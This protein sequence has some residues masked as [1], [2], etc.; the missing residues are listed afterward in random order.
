[1]LIGVSAVNRLDSKEWY[2]RDWFAKEEGLIG[3]MLVT[4]PYSYQ[5]HIEGM[6]RLLLVVREQVCLDQETEHWLRDQVRIQVRRVKPAT[7]ERWVA[8]GERSVV[9]WLVQGEVLSD[10]TGYLQELRCR[11]QEW[12][13]LLR[14]QKLLCEFSGFIRTYM[15]A[16]QDL[17]NGQ[18]LDSYSNVLASLQYWA[19]IA[20]IEEGLHPELTVWGQLRK[21]NPGIYKLYEELTT[22]TDTLEKRAQ[23]VLLACEFSVLTKMRSSCALLIR[24]LASRDKPWTVA[25]LQQE[26]HLLG[27]PLDLSLLLQK[28]AKR[29]CI[30]ELAT[31]VR[32]HGTM[33]RELRYAAADD[34]S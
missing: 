15:L 10:P 22:S 30:R 25:E 2:Y 33:K 7:L 28:L 16:K 5:P 17:K 27:L 18:V 23:L 13:P 19:H 20:L 3:L 8:S 21:V 12:P 31:P 14:E 11:L 34:R 32:G 24:L 1:M 26:P 6:D 9:Q 29:G 4:D